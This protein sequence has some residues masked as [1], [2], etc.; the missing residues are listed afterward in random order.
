MEIELELFFWHLSIMLD[1]GKLLVE[2]R[3][4]WT[5]RIDGWQRREIQT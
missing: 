5:G 2:P 3:G 1:K 4:T